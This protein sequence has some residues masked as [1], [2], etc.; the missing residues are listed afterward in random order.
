MGIWAYGHMGI[1]AYG[2]IGG[3]LW[4]YT[5]GIWTYRRRSIWYVGIWTWSVKVFRGVGYIVGGQGGWM[6][7]VG[8]DGRVV[9]KEKILYLL[10]RGMQDGYR[11][12]YCICYSY[13][14]IKR[15]VKNK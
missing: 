1:W 14:Y 13:S 2:H 8:E 4:D 5:M 15:G 3:S 11:Y 12:G 9:V 7:E 10:D 6:E